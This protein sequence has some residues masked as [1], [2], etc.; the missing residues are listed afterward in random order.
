MQSI[1][2]SFNIENG[3]ENSSII[4][5]YLQQFTQLKPLVMVLKVFLLQRGIN[6]PYSGGLG[7]YA[8]LLMIVNFLQL[9]TI[10]IPKVMFQNLGFL[11][12]EFFLHYGRKFNYYVLGITTRNGGAHFL[13]AHKD[14]LEYSK[15]WLLAI[16][17]PQDPDN[18]VGRSSHR[19]V[20]II[21]H[22][23]LTAYIRLVSHPPI[24]WVPTPLSRVI[25]PEDPMLKD[26]P[27]AKTV[28][29]IVSIPHLKDNLNHSH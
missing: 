10:S 18:D 26:R 24:N 27:K 21:Q 12:I 13:K 14:W 7:S 4:K 29:S 25:Y 23:F 3:V 17:D 15:P 22:A 28:E 8:L 20:P 6:E 2:I 16:E 19:I 1:D 5:E 11:L 9:H